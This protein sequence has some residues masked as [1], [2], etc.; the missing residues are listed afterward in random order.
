MFFTSNFACGKLKGTVRLE[1]I[2]IDSSVVVGSSNTL[3]TKR[4][5]NVPI[6]GIFKSDLLIGLDLLEE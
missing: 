5:L 4:K 3:N 1:P 6:H 2:E